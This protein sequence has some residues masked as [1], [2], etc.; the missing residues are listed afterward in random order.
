[1][2]R[3]IKKRKATEPDT[4]YSN[5]LVSKFINKIMQEGKKPVAKRIVY[6]ALDTLEKQAKKPAMEVFEKAMNNVFPTVE[7]RSKRI[8]GANYQVPIEVRPERRIALGIRWI[9]DS[10]RSQK[11]KPMANKLAEEFLNAFNN[12]G[13]AVKKKQDVQR[14]AE[15]NKAF[16]HFAW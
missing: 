5:V 10:A 6:S 8:G 4:K 2:R 9:I 15:A 3:L 16:A 11:G 7:L 14:M 13:G 12:T 1:V